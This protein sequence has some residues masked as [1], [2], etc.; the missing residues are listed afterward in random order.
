MNWLS[1]KVRD[2]VEARACK[3]FRK[4]YRRI[5]PHPAKEDVMPPSYEA[6]L[7]WCRTHSGY[8]IIEVIRIENEVPLLRYLVYKESVYHEL[9]ASWK[10]EYSEYYALRILPKG[11]YNTLIPVAKSARRRLLNDIVKWY[12]WPF[13][14]GENVL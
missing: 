7:D 3:H 11:L 5:W 13:V 2:K 14:L 6:C 9:V 10:I 4:G 8:V 12:E 1:K